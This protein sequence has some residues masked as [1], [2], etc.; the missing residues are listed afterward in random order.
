ML[1]TLTEGLLTIQNRSHFR[2]CHC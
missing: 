2:F 1:Y